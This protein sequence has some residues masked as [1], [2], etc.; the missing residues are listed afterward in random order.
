MAVADKRCLQMDLL[1]V[2]ICLFSP[3][4]ASSCNFSRAKAALMTRWACS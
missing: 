4:L 3:A 1:T 2:M